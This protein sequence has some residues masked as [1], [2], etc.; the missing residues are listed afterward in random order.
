MVGD[1]LATQRPRMRRGGTRDASGARVMKDACVGLLAVLCGCEEI[2]ERSLG[3][4]GRT[5][6]WIVNDDC[7]GGC[8]V[9]VPI[10]VGAS[11]VFYVE[12]RYGSPVTEWS[13]SDDGPLDVVALEVEEARPGGDDRDRVRIETQATGAGESTIAVHDG[14]LVD[15]VRV[16]TRDAGTVE[17]GRLES[18]AIGYDLAGLEASTTLSVQPEPG[19]DLVWLACRVSDTSGVPLLT[20]HGQMAWEII[21]GADIVE[22]DEGWA[23]TGW[24]TRANGARIAV[25][26]NGTGT[27]RARVTLGDLVHELALIA[28]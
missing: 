8:G 7:P 15:R 16:T 3:E 6:W 24:S 26:T 22:L 4:E 18:R 23:E 27:A 14:V 19:D 11:P 9:D 21:E 13:S 20:T 5:V 1:A 12:D 25:R 10:A 2:D 28:E 17:C